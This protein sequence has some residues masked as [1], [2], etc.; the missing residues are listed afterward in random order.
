MTSITLGISFVGF[1][2]SLYN[3]IQARRH[4]SKD[5]IAKFKDIPIFEYRPSMPPKER[6]S[7]E[8]LKYYK[9]FNV[10]MAIFVIASLPSLI[11]SAYH[12]Y[13]DSL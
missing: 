5:K 12:A 6:L 1:A 11:E 8:G 2:Y 4:I 13:L 7:D 10:G 9:G 3:Q